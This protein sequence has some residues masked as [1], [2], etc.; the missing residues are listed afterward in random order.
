MRT[1]QE[2]NEFIVTK[3]YL[4]RNKSFDYSVALQEIV[5]VLN[6]DENVVFICATSDFISGA[7]TYKNGAVAVTNERIIYSVKE[8]R[9]FFKNPVTKSISLEFVSDV[10]KSH[11]KPYPFGNIWIDTLNDKFNFCAPMEQLD[12][13]YNKILAAIKK[14]GEKDVNA[15][16]LS[17]ADEIKKFKDLLDSGVITQEEFNAKKKQ[18]LGL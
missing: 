7:F 4:N 1:V 18:L 9:M 11:T 2:L 8:N 17:S 5:Q 6:A 15:N 14:S 13:M 16:N 12:E 10:R 3:Q